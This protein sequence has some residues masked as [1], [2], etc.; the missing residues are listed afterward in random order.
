VTADP[1]NRYHVLFHGTTLHGMEA[2]DPARQD[3]PLTY[4]HRTGP[5]GQAYSRLPQLSGA[6][7]IAAV[8][9]GVGSLASYAHDG[10]RW[11]FYEIDPAVERIA[12]SDAF[13]YLR[14]CGD[15]CRVVIGD[16]R[17]SLARTTERFGLIVLDAFSSDA[18]PIH[19][20]TAEAM[21]MYLDRL[22]PSG[23]LAFHISNR[24]LRLGPVLARIA[25]EQGLSSL[26]QVDRVRQGATDEGKRSSHWVL[27]ARSAADLAPLRGDARWTAPDVPPKTPIWRDDFSNILSVMSWR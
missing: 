19:L 27:I 13:G 10:Q 26:E 18:I 9:L 12:R 24:Y 2:T 6:P 3:E 20:M 8:G 16:A 4:Y 14:R 7:E 5:F 1:A 22:A 23:A 17:Q 15:R 11:T 21:A 25:A